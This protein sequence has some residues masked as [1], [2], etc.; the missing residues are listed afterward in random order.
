MM[1]MI[2][3]SLHRRHLKA[4]NSTSEGPKETAAVADA[5][6]GSGVVLCYA[7]FLI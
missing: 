4:V 5:V 6:V 2:M 1:M 3:M 7:P